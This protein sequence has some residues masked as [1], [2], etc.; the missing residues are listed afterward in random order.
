MGNKVQWR[1]SLGNCGASRTTNT[2]FLLHSLRPMTTKRHRVFFSCRSVLFDT[3]RP[4]SFSASPFAIVCRSEF[5]LDSNPPSPL[6]THTHT[7]IL[8]LPRR[9]CLTPAWNQFRSLHPPT[10]LHQRPFSLT[11][12]RDRCCASPRISTHKPPTRPPPAPLNIMPPSWSASVPFS[13]VK[14]LCVHCCIILDV[15]L[16][17]IFHQKVGLDLTI[18]WN[19]NQKMKEIQK[20]RHQVLSWGLMVALWSLCT[21]QEESSQAPK[22]PLIHILPA[23]GLNTVGETKKWQGG[24]EVDGKSLI[25]R[26]VACH[27]QL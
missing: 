25:H 17:Q 21:R 19:N 16:R 3:G 7:R 10:T 12:K 14:I 26:V 15:K 18:F 11:M 23:L 5:T 8:F 22:C 6:H 13:R 1:C 20:F 2:H 9:L 24:W 27:T 4:L